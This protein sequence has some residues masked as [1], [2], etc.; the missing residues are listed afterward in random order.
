MVMIVQQV[1]WMIGK[2]TE[3]L[4]ENLSQC[5]SGHHRFHKIGPGLEPGASAVGGRRLIA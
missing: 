3:I 1:E 5:R 4:E 2:G